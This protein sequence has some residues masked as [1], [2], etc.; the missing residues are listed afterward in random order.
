MKAIEIEATVEKHCIRL[1][2]AIPDG[3]HLR[4]DGLD[5]YLTVVPVISGADEQPLWP[6]ARRD[7]RN[8]GAYPL[9]E[10]VSVKGNWF[11]GEEGIQ[12]NLP[13][14]AQWEYACRA[15]TATPF[16]FGAD[17]RAFAAHANLAD[18]SF[19]RTRPIEHGVPESLTCLV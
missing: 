18:L 15:G 7:G 8:S 17:G 16:W 10:P 3:T 4:V 2:D 13:T 19:R 11:S 5:E 14:E 9:D 1:P 6:S 12:Y